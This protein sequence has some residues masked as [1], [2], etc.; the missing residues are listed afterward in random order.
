M[1]TKFAPRKH[2]SDHVFEGLERRILDPRSVAKLIEYT[3]LKPS[4]TE[5]DIRRLCVE[6]KRYG[7]ATVCINPIYVPLAKKLLLGSGVRVCT[8]VGF[9]TG[10]NLQRG[11]GVRGYEIF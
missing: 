7:F 3:L 11:Q 2:T 8:A 9:P 5:E 4:A 10:I 1:S 6:A